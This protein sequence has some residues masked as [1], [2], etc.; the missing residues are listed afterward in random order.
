MR[1]TLLPITLITQAIGALRVMSNG[2]N[3]VN[4]LAG[5][6][7]LRPCQFSLMMCRAKKLGLVLRRA[8][9]QTPFRCVSM[10]ASVSS[11]LSGRDRA[12]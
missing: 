8:L 12:S 1:L 11:A 4:Y 3:H 2:V 7:E 9:S 5:T 6:M 10:H